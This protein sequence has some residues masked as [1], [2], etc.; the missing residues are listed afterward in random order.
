[1]DWNPRLEKGWNPLVK[2]GSFTGWFGKGLFIGW[3]PPVKIKIGSFTGWN[4]LINFRG[5]WGSWRWA[6]LFSFISNSVIKL[7]IN[8]GIFI[9]IYFEFISNCHLIITTLIYIY[10]Y[11]LNSTSTTSSCRWASPRTAA[12]RRSCRATRT[13]WGQASR[14]VDRPCHT[15]RATR[16]VPHVP[17]HTRRAMCAVPHVPCHTHNMG[18]GKQKNR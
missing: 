14:R 1:M 4:P 2:K 17:C 5:S 11:R 10:T 8:M 12:V 13:T 3:N 7:L 15:C 16:A 18:P 9:L 6:S